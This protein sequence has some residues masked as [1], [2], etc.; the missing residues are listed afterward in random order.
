MPKCDGN[1]KVEA[2]E[3]GLQVVD[4]FQL[5]H[6]SV[7]IRWDFVSVSVKFVVV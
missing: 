7:S 2:Q 4:W 3:I 5:L 1:I 6:A